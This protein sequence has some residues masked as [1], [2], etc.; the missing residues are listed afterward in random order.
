MTDKNFKIRVRQW[1]TEASRL[2]EVLKEGN[3]LWV[4]DKYILA[5]SG[6]TEMK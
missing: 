5:P 4:K 6:T 3:I 2:C 1:Q